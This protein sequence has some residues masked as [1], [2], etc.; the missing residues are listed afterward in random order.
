[1]ALMKV[2]SSKYKKMWLQVAFDLPTNSPLERR[3]ASKFRNNLLESGFQM[4]HFSVY[5]RHAESPER[6]NSLISKIKEKIPRKGKVFLLKITDK[7]MSN[8]QIIEDFEQKS[9][10]EPPDIYVCI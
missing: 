8:M 5:I 6:A 4:L 7:Q 1:M 9:G 3:Q 10:P 2:H